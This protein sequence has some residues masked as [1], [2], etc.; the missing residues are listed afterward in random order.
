MIE[1]Q[2][3]T[4]PHIPELINELKL[5]G[6][7]TPASDNI[8]YGAPEGYHERLRNRP[9]LS[10]MATKAKRSAREDTRWIC[11]WPTRISTAAQ[12]S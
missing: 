10:S 8:Q 4:I 5:Y 9:S 12:L 3:I 11:R 6:Y 2:Q 7:K 1:N